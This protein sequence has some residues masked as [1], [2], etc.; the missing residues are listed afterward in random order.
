MDS[1]IAVRKQAISTQL[2]RLGE[3]AS[4]VGLAH[5]IELFRFSACMHDSFRFAHAEISLAL[6]NIA[7]CS[8]TCL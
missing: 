8:R 5:C 4:L 7:S 1:S 2:R 3:G 6:V